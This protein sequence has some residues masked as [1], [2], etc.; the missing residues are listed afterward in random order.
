MVKLGN[1]NLTLQSGWTI[2]EDEN[3]LLT[4]ELSY[5]G[6]AL[7]MHALPV[8]WGLGLLHP[9][10]YRLTAYRRRLQR[11]QASKVRITLSFIG[12]MSDPTPW[13]IEHPGGNG[14][15]PIETHPDFT[16]FAGTATSPKNGAKFDTSTGEFLGFFDPTKSLAG[17]R[18]YIVPNVLVSATY[19]THYIPNLGNV[20]RISGYP[21]ISAPPNVR[22][23]LLLACPYKQIGNLYQVTH[24]YLGSGPNGWNRSIY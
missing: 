10:D 23:F 21:P 6:D 22:N 2:D 7:F 3:G 4:G 20:G 14:Q 16:T 19:Y 12:I 13:V 18:S 9:Y 1:P 8:S 11:L 5:E 24:Q 17:V 15:E